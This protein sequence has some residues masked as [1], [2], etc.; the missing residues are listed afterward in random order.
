M[1]IAAGSTASTPARSAS[2]F[3][4]SLVALG[5]LSAI[6]F[7]IIAATPY[8]TLQPDAFG[9]APDINWPRRLPLW[10]HIGGGSLALL[11]GPINLWL[12]ETRRRLPWHRNLGFGYL[13]GVAVGAAAAFYLSFTTPLGWSFGSALFTLGIAWSL[14]TAMA[15]LAISRRAIVQHREWMIRSYV[16][17][18]AFVLFRIIYGFIEAQQIGTGEE[19]LAMAAWS[20]FA[21]SP[22]LTEV[23]LQWRKVKA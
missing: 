13:A 10:L 22:V 6:A 15:F 5:G 4:V 8:F 7:W 16:F 9:P 1:S 12:G 23:V 2:W 20:C 14:T 11:L 17:T 3:Y 18:L 19:R 21:L